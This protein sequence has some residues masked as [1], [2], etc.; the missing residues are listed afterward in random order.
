MATRLT[1][2]LCFRGRFEFVLYIDG[3]KG[4]A[5]AACRAEIYEHSRLMAVLQLTEAV[6]RLEIADIALQRCVRWA[7]LRIKQLP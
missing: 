6:S 2:P 1:T 3:A 4:C 7:E 5:S